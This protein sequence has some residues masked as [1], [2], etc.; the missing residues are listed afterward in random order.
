MEE[1]QRRASDGGGRGGSGRQGKCDRHERV[2]A[3]RV[4]EQ[5]HLLIRGVGSWK[6][7]A[8]KRLGGGQGCE[9]RGDETGE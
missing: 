3:A 1:S 8:D 4:V 6:I 7:P 5:S 2:K 9:Q